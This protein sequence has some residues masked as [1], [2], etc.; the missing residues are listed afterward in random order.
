MNTSIEHIPSKHRFE[1]Q[2]EGLTAHV[3]Y[4]IGNGYLDIIHTFVPQPLEGRGFAGELVKATFDYALDQGL[5]PHGSCSYAA[6][7]LKRHPEY[8]AAD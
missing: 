5:R 4:E 1:L 3:E 8:L 2:R 6:I 7:W